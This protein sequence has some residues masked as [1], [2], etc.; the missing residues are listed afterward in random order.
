MTTRYKEP[1]LKSQ[2]TLQ[3]SKICKPQRLK[4]S[5]AN[6]NRFDSGSEKL[7]SRKPNAH[8]INRSNA[9]V[10]ASPPTLHLTSPEQS[11]PTTETPL[12]QSPEQTKP[13]L[14]TTVQQQ[15]TKSLLSKNTTT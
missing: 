12:E 14:T 4:K 2:R 7:I 1:D 8:V 15:Q 3:I 9:N 5:P 6:L 11:P 13:L 10:A